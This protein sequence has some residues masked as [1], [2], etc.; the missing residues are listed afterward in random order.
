[1]NEGLLARAIAARFQLPA[2]QAKATLAFVLSTIAAALKR[3]E[4][5]YFRSTGVFTK[6]IRPGRRV[7]H[8]KTGEII[9]IPP[10]PDVDFKASRQLL[11]ALAD[12]KRSRELRSKRRGL[13]PR[14]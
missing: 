2:P 8:P 5:V 3:G 11:R 7:R 12:R 10:R 14:P 1:V 6:V 4:L 13:K 9:W